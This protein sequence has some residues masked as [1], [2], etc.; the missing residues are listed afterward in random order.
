MKLQKTKIP[1]IHNRAYILSNKDWAAFQIS[2][3]TIGVVSNCRSL[4]DFVKNA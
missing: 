1:H 2:I 3:P 4:T